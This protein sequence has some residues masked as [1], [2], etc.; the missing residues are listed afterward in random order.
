[1]WCDLFQ[2]LNPRLVILFGSYA[3]GN[4]TNNSDVDILV[5]SDKLPKDPREAFR[6]AYRI[7][8]PRVIPTAY[9]TEV[10]LK[11]LRDGST[12][13]LEVIEDGVIMC[14]DEGFILTVKKI[15]QE[16]RKRYRREG[17]LWIW[18]E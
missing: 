18:N 15:F 14:G 10:F 12:F 6:M 5:V 9:N 7:E 8:E 16:V 17:K 3:R 2:D 13:L 4:Y 1:M 11:K